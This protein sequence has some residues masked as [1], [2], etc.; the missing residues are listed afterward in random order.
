MGGFAE[1]ATSILEQMA[2]K[3]AV[4]IKNIVISSNIQQE[5]FTFDEGNTL[6]SSQDLLIHHI[7][8]FMTL[9]VQ[10]AANDICQLFCEC[11]SLLRSQVSHGEAQV[12]ELK[13][14]LDVAEKSLSMILENACAVVVDT[15]A[16]E[17]GGV[18]EILQ[19]ETQ[20]TAMPG[21]VEKSA[22]L[23]VTPYEDMLLEPTQIII[24]DEMP[25]GS[26]QQETKSAPDDHHVD[27]DFERLEYATDAD[28]TSQTKS[29]EPDGHQLN[30]LQVR[31]RLEKK[32]MCSLCGCSFPLQRSLN[33]HMRQHTGQGQHTGKRAHTCN[34]CGKGFTLRQILL[35]HQRLHNDDRPY[36][37][38]QCDKSFYRVNGLKMHKR[39]HAIRC[40]RTGE[41]RCHV[42]EKKFSLQSNLRRHMRIH[43]G[44]KPYCCD[45]CGKSFNQA[46]TLKIHQRIHTG[47][48]PFIC[49]TCGKTFI[50]KG[51]LKA[52][53]DAASPACVACGA[54]AACADAMRIHIQTHADGVQCACMLCGHWLTTVA[55]LRSH[56]Q[57]HQTATRAHGCTMCGKRFMSAS[58]LKIHLRL[59][60]GVKKPFSCN[61]CL[62]T[63]SQLSSLKLH[64]EIHIGEKPYSCD[65]CGKSYSD[66][67]L[68]TR[69]RCNINAEKGTVM[70][71]KVYTCEICNKH[72]KHAPNLIRHRRIHT[73]EKPYVCKVCGRSFNQSNSLKAHQL[74]HT[75]LKRFICGSCNKGFSDKRNL[76]SHKCS[77]YLTA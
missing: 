71:E 77:Y 45:T 17:G 37:C 14:R 36:K 39:L 56:Q 54:V 42:C 52:H 1:Q 66:V 23:D 21:E 7:E 49:E 51:T 46:D 9:L 61:V 48:R 11:S 65:K 32:F 3:V 43:T 34:T 74:T 55:E 18:A 59:H 16:Q 69:H 72:F 75:G 64:Q 63:F 6:I 13:N 40:V 73:G 38:T 68:L 24:V 4:E 20:S 10:E 58:Y 22:I 29:K 26:D 2:N 35:D 67:S 70:D 57:E 15:E 25:L 76:K 33:A 41:H 44:E 60:T 50:Q 5:F 30:T 12:E 19:L 8:A 53:T 31:P 62:R 27:V 28:Q 47:E